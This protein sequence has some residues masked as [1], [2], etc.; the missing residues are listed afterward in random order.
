TRRQ[1][2]RPS[3]LEIFPVVA[4]KDAALEAN[5]AGFNIE[6]CQ[7]P[8]Q[9]RLAQ[10]AAFV[11]LPPRRIFMRYEGAHQALASHSKLVI[12]IEAS[13]DVRQQLD[14]LR[15]VAPWS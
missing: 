4:L 5:V 12:V 14:G 8:R 13:P 7:E 3:I 10:A 15:I 11:A 9:P 1:V 2:S 6:W